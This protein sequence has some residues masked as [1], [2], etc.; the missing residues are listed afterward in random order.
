MVSTTLTSRAA[1]R[2]GVLLFGQRRAWRT[3]LLA[4]AVL[5][6][7]ALVGLIATYSRAEP[8]TI[9]IAN[10]RT[11]HYLQNFHD[12][13]TQPNATQPSYRWTRDRSTI[14][15]PGLGRGVWQLQ[16]TLSSP[17]PADHPKQVL[18]DNGTHQLP[19]QLERG[20]RVYELL[21]PSAG[22]MEVALEAPTATYGHD[23]RALGVAFFGTTFQPVL[24]AAFPPLGQLLSIMAALMLAFITLRFIGTSPTIALA[25]PLVGL[26]LAIWGITTN[27]APLG[28]LGPRLAILAVA[29]MP[30]V[31]ILV[32]SWKRLVALGRF[33]TQPWLQ[34]ALLT[35]FYIGFWIKATGLLYPYSHAI[36][37]D[38][39]MRH[40]QD[41]L[42][43]QLL[44]LYKPGA[45]SESV[46]P[47]K[48]W[49]EQRPVIPY[50][51]FFH[52]FATS[53]AI[54]PWSLVTTANIFS[55][56]FDTNRVLLIAALALA[57]GLSSRGALLAVLL[58][59]V[60]PF[61]FL[62]HS[63]G[64]IPTT[65][66]IWW[67]LFATT[68]LVL[69]HGRWRERRIQLLLIGVLL[70]TFLFYTVMAVFML[71]FL[72]L[73][74]VSLCIWR[75]GLPP[76]QASAL[77]FVA[78]IAFGLSLIIYYGQYIPPVIERT[79]P[80]LQ[81]TVVQG[82][83]NEG[84]TNQEPFLTYIY[85]YGGRLGYTALPVRYGLWIPLLIAIPGLWLLRRQ[86]LALHVFGAWATVATLFLI[87]GN[88]VPMVDKH[89]FYI[90][91]ALVICTAAVLDR[92]L[93]YNRLYLLAI[94]GIYLVTFLSALELWIWRLQEV[95]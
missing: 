93:S 4:L 58:Y 6:M 7:A 35:I 90:A 55:V 78:A 87:L 71:V 79:L 5:L 89:I 62:L 25:L 85:L 66:G 13:E 22:D 18:L 33:E 21:L 83:S 16:I 14:A 17:Q 95:Q 76:K 8:F 73:L 60:T 59:A 20:P 30:L 43:G 81:H 10:A 48:E 24:I 38:W 64:N 19:I 26:A 45:F 40:T 56:F 2:G 57:F 82:G 27:R 88:R 75:R 94:G 72:A 92:L 70:L 29:G 80:Y 65:F 9:D 31:A 3:D 36:D 54:F 39:H 51:P 1:S 34:T 23:S 44:E 28:L 52:I 74:F 67:T 86:R 46:M 53:F 68:L 11:R 15:A 61:T 63:W 41:I 12:P 32:W 84:Q 49:G 91:P 69:T 77:F 50:S 42:N 47:V 37:V